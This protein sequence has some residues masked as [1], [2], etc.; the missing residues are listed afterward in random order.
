MAQ[1]AIY[2][3]DGHG[4]VVDCQSDLLSDLRSRAVAPLREAGEDSVALSRLNPCIAIDGVAY[5]V[6]T[7]FLRSVD[8]RLLGEQVGSADEIE[9]EIKAASDM[10][11]SGF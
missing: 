7:L 6:A 2:R 8:R 1:F 5:R 9:R 10:L 3:L 11:I 4:L